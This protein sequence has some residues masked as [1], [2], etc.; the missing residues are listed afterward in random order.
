M[1]KFVSPLSHESLFLSCR[2][3]S[4]CSFPG[5]LKLLHNKYNAKNSSTKIDHNSLFSK[6]LLHSCDALSN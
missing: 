1:L 2:G 4:N 3:F 5:W 6:E